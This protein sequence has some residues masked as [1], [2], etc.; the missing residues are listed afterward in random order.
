[1]NAFHDDINSHVIHASLDLLSQIAIKPSRICT[2]SILIIFNNWIIKLVT[3]AK[4]ER[5]RSLCVDI[6]RNW[7]SPFL[8]QYWSNDLSSLL[9]K[10][11]FVRSLQLL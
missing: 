4:P 3:F 8:R 9:L 2:F 7:T 1:M 6:N 10:V 11:F 5:L